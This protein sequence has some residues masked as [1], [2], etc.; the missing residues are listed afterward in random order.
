MKNKSLLRSYRIGFQQNLSQTKE[1]SLENKSLKLREI[2][3]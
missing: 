3:I 2:L 1:K